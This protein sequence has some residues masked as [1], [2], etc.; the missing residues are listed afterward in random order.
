[1]K[2]IVIGGAIAAATL[3]LYPEPASAQRGINAGYC[4]S[5]PVQTC[6]KSGTLRAQNVKNC[7]VANCRDR[8]G[9]R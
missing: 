7:S 3:L 2:A 9:S 8:F 5:Q 1:M 6:S 4:P